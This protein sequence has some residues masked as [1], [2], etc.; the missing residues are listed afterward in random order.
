M[1]EL[2]E[3]VPHVEV[4]ANDFVVCYSNWSKQCKTMT[5]PW[6]CFSNY[7]RNTDSHWKLKLRQTEVS[8]IGHVATG[9]GLWVDPAKVKAIRNMPP[10][11]DKAGMQ[12]LLGLA[13]YLSKFLPNLS[14]IE[15]TQQQDRVVLRWCT[16]LSQFKEAVWYG[17]KFIHITRLS[18][19]LV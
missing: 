3:G 13:Q 7:A 15:L 14:D 8:L 2:I 19:R 10:S 12:R 4:A 11:T 16:E 17:I 6:W 18:T 9:D 5:R 1:H